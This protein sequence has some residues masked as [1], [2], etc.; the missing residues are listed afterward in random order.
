MSDRSGR[1]QIYVMN[2]DGSNVQRL[3]NS[4]SEDGLPA[5]SPDGTRIAFTRDVACDNYYSACHNI[6]V[7]NPDGSDVVRFETRSHDSEPA[8]SPDSQWIVFETYYCT[9]YDCTD[10]SISAVRRNGTGRAVVVAGN[11]HN[12]AWRP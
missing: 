9:Y 7:M 10:M 2:A 4:T 5:W 8:W 1:S 12:P 6:M 3:T 11:L